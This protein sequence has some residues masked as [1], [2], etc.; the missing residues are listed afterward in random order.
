MGAYI[1]LRLFAGFCR[2]F[3]SMFS[4]KDRQR[5]IKVGWHGMPRC[6]LGVTETFLMHAEIFQLFS[7]NAIV[8]LTSCS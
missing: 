4:E 8:Q 6:T 5:I 3:S 7:Q 2:V 1:F